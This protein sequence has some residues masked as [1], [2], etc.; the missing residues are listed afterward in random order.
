MST[1]REFLQMSLAASTLPTLVTPSFSRDNHQQLRA[2]CVVA[3]AASP[4]AASFC[5]EA[6]RLGLRAHVIND[7]ITD[8][9]YREFSIRWREASAVVAGVTLSTSLFCL[10]TLARDHGMRVWFRAVHNALPDGQIEHVVFG[11]EPIVQL[12]AAFGVDWG[13]DFARLA[14]GAPLIAANKTENRIV[15]SAAIRPNEPGPIVSWIIVP[16]LA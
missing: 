15:R 9:W 16:R 6:A 14:A 8:L 12:S 5:D 3:E 10:E 2:S 4:L 13:V 7:D 11:P 1:R